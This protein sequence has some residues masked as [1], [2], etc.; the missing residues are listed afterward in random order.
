MRMTHASRSTL[1]FSRA[2]LVIVFAAAAATSGR[3]PVRAQQPTAGAPAGQTST[4]RSATLLPDGRSLLIG[5]E[6]TRASSRSSASMD[7][8]ALRASR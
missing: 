1:L 8:H 5:G 4:G 7:R 3:A 6:Q 2:L